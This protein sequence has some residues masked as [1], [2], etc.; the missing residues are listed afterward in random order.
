MLTS[1]STFCEE[2]RRQW[3]E[4]MREEAKQQ[5]SMIE[6]KKKV[7]STA[8]FRLLFQEFLVSV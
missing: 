8:I 3:T 2:F 5:I 4:E 7:T 1:L 6:L